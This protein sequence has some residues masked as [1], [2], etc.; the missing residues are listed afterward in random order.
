MFRGKMYE[1]LNTQMDLLER[2]LDFE[3]NLQGSGGR[4]VTKGFLMYRLELLEK[5]WRS[6]GEAGI[7]GS[8]WPAAL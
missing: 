2:I 7:R 3:K 8:L 5:S 1:L 4:S 6:L